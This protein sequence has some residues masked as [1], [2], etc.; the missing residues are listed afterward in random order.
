[1]NNVYL[2]Y[3]YKNSIRIKYGR[4]TWGCTFD[5][6]DGE[7]WMTHIPDKLLVKKFNKVAVES[8]DQIPRAIE[9]LWGNE[10]KPCKDED[11]LDKLEA[12]VYQ[13]T[14][15]NNDILR[16]I[17]RIEKRLDALEG[18]R[19][20]STYGE[21]TFVDNFIPHPKIEVLGD[22]ISSKGKDIPCIP[23]SKETYKRSSTDGFKICPYCGRNWN[24]THNRMMGL[25]K[26]PIKI[27]CG[28]CKKIF[29][30]ASFDKQKWEYVYIKDEG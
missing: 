20:K 14:A 2:V 21:K 1:M 27:R 7:T 29:T 10:C 23:D 5:P 11:K 22:I 9:L 30:V 19:S 8:P 3:K 26:G 18:K 17:A 28:K 24:M 6:V 25:Y 16:S 12:A 15:T 4:I 13:N